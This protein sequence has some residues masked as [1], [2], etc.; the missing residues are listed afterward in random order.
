MMMDQQY[1]SGLG[2]RA[3]ITTAS[4]G[5]LSNF[6]IRDGRGCIVVSQAF[7]SDVLGDFADALGLAAQNLK[8]LSQGEKT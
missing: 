3:D 5:R 2:L 8:M 7:R 4:D 6:N 1:L